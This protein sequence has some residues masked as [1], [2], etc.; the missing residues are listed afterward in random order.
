MTT[1]EAPTGAALS[2]QPRVEG[3]EKV[4]GTAKYAYEQQFEGAVKA[5]YTVTQAMLPLLQRA[6]AGARPLVLVGPGFSTEV[7]ATL[8]ANTTQ[9][10][11]QCVPV[12]AK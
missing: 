8:A 2:Q 6:Q 4:S 12:V 7:L 11:Q 10:K 3:V 9:G 5:A 1:T